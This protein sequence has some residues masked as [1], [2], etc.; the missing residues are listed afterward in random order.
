MQKIKFIDLESQ[1]KSIRKNIDDAISRVLNHG[2]FIM[3]E[4]VLKFESH[5]KKFTNSN[6]VISC[7]NGTDALSIVL[8]AWNIKPGDVVFVP[9]FTYVSSAETIAQIGAIPFL[10]M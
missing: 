4:E 3:G 10:L 8:M 9:S 2:N 5:L 1:Q 7:G 6:F